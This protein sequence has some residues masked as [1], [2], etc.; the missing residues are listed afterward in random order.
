MT[1]VACCSGS[2]QYVPPYVIMKGKRKKDEYA[3]GLPPGSK[4]SLSDS[5][6]INTEL[7]LD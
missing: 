2:G 5:G 3:D 7:F 6:Y 1:V 4:L